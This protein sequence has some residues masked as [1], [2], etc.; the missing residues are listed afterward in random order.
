M[1]EY[2][3]PKEV[4]AILRVHVCTVYEMIHQGTIKALRL[5]RAY[6]IHPDAI[7]GLRLED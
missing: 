7:A 4:A 1:V 6:R 3:T 5:K 2:L